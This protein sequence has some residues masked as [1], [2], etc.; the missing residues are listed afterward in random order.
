MCISIGRHHIRYAI[1][2]HTGPLDHRTVRAGYNFNSPHR[3]AHHPKPESVARLFG[4]FHIAGAL[5]L[6]IDTIKRGDDDEDVSVDHLPK[7]KGKNII[8][9]IFDSLGGKS[10]GKL[11]WGDIPV[12]KV[13]ETNLLEDDGKELPISEDGGHVVITARAF[14]ILTLRLQL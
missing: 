4:S 10:T 3:L 1:L 5:N 12:K 8:V 11:H 6:V 7:R 14:E 2:P 13:Y 9:R